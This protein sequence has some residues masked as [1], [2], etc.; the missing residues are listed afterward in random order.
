M[1]VENDV[2][3][4]TTMSPQANGLECESTVTQE[5]WAAI[6][7]VHDGAPVSG[8]TPDCRPYQRQV[9]VD[10]PC[11]PAVTPPSL[12]FLGN[13]SLIL[14]HWSSLSSFRLI[15]TA[16]STS[17][18]DTLNLGVN[19]SQQVLDTYPDDAPHVCKPTVSRLPYKRVA[20]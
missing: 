10:T 19:R 17:W 9:R 5:L 7:R 18:S 11:S 15:K 3:S 2:C 1:R 12:D 4:G 14:S 16:P 20:R 6:R 8:A 13:R